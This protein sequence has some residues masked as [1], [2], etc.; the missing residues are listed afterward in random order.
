MELGPVVLLLTTNNA[1]LQALYA[2]LCYQL[3]NLIVGIIRLSGK[4]LVGITFIACI[5]S[6]LGQDYG[7]AFYISI[8]LGNC[9]CLIFLTTNWW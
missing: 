7:P 2:G 3:G 9:N 5:C 1:I 6:I 4:F 8:T